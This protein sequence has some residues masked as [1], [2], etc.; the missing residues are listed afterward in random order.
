MEDKLD[1][2]LR[3]QLVMQG[4]LKVIEERLKGKEVRIS[5]NEKSVESLKKFK[6]GIIGTA[7]ISVASFF[8]SMF[9]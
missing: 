9:A 2:L 6:W 7:T 3:G 8:R 1:E 4:D 5:N